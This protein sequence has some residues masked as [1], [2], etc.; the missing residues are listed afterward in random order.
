MGGVHHVAT[1]TRPPDIRELAQRLLASPDAILPELSTIT[2]GQLLWYRRALETYLASL[3]DHAVAR[4][5]YGEL[6]WLL[7]RLGRQSKARIKAERQARQQQLNKTSLSMT[8][9]ATPR[10]RGSMPW[11]WQVRRL[12][13]NTDALTLRRRK[14]R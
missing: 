14:P 2:M 5:D 1:A 8:R 13:A 4:E 7:N 11:R 6:Q 12:G 10:K 3:P 9:P